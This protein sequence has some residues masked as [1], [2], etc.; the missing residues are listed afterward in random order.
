MLTRL[1]NALLAPWRYS[2]LAIQDAAFN[3]RYVRGEQR[4]LVVHHPGVAFPYAV[5][6]HWLTL[7]FPEVRARFE[8]H[9]LP[10]RVG[11]WSQYALHIPWLRDPV[12]DWSR[13]CYRFANR[14]AAQCD[15]RDIPVINRVDRLQNATKSTGAGLIA[16]VGFTTPR[17]ARIDNPDEF[18]RT[19]LGLRLP[20]LVREDWG[21][22]GPMLRADSDAEVRALPLR[23]FRRPVAAEL[24]DVRSASDGL[25]R[26][27]RYVVAG[28]TGVRQSLHISQ[29]WEVRG[30]P[31]RTVYT[32]ALRDE[33]IAYTS[34]PE[35]EHARFVAATKA[36]GLDFVAFDYSLDPDGRSVVWE[37]NPFPLLH[38]L[39]G[40]RRYRVVPT[41]RVLAA[42]TK[43]YL[44]RAGLEVPED[45]DRVAGFELLE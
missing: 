27:Y 8:L 41:A 42:V 17:M 1:T 28:D 11:G 4:F 21:H 31:E 38:F 7:Y 20:I 22:G 30:A 19:R 2:G 37:A 34:A 16:S 3:R 15:H 36:L 43:L 26:K 10:T 18:H 32:D 39:G 6:L 35:P 40:R 5:L 29:H 13:M 44:T 25:Y 33:E 24:V 9:T 23:T 14:I 12:Q 45:L